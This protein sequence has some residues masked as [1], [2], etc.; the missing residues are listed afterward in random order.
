MGSRDSRRTENQELFRIGNA[1]LIDVVD[2]RVPADAPLPF[3][4]ECAEEG[5]NARV[6]IDRLQWQDISSR[7]NH[8]VL[9][10]GHP[11]ADGELVVEAI[12]DYEVV[13]KPD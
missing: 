2:A 4:C 12:G 9:V 11:R 8:F 10:A 13:R 3:L 5:C 7:A 1:R 6:E